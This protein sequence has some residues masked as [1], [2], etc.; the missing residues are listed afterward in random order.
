M[1][2]RHCENMWLLESSGRANGK[3]RLFNCHDDNSPQNKP[4]RMSRPSS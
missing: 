1:P 4:H 2:S 3:C